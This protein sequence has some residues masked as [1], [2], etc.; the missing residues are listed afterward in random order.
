MTQEWASNLVKGCD[1]ADATISD[2]NKGGVEGMGTTTHMYLL[3]TLS[4]SDQC[5]IAHS[6]PLGGGGRVQVVVLFFFFF[7]CPAGV[8]FCQT[9]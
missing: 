1:A 4:Y 8:P 9:E 6:E 5:C 7:F 3:T 2:N